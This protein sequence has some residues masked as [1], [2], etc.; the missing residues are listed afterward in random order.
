MDAYWIVSLRCKQNVQKLFPYAKVVT[1]TTVFLF[2]HCSPK[3]TTQFTLSR[4]VYQSLIN[5]GA[6]ETTWA[7]R[8]DSSG[9]HNI[10]E[11]Q[12]KKQYVQKMQQHFP[13]SSKNK[14]DP[15]S[16]PDHKWQKTPNH[17]PADRSFS[18][19]QGSQIVTKSVQIPTK[20]QTVSW[21]KYQV[22]FWYKNGCY[23]IYAEV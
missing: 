11:Q 8:D 5:D 3:F 15:L 1:N 21:Q 6:S 17:D 7:Q 2:Y 12:M 9:F 16:P 23:H 13:L 20:W 19:C 4:H 22:H 18:G 10:S 14:P